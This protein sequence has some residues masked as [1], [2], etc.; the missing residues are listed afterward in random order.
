MHKLVAIVLV[1]CSALSI[2]DEASVNVVNFDTV[3]SREVANDTAQATL[4]VELSDADPARLSERVNLAVAAG[5]KLARQSGSA[6]S[7]NTGYSTYP[8][9]NK[10]NKQEGWRA[11]GELRLTSHD[12]AALARLIGELQ[13]MQGGLPLQLAE[14]RYSVSDEA[15]KK[16]EDELIEEGLRGFRSR[17]ALMQKGL[18]GKSW[19]LLNLTVN[20]QSTRPPVLYRAAPMAEMALA[21]S[22]APVEGG[23]SRLSVSIQGRIQLE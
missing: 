21:A 17:A 20:T 3:A 4:F 7:I 2:A 5:V 9:Y 10:S 6:Q 14:V 13:K 8:L 11:R 18:N 19:K 12:F 23:E 1:L 22:P 16:A 15:R